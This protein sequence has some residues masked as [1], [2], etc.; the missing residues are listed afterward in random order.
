MG[1]T[2]QIR[3][4]LTSRVGKGKRFANNKRMADELEVDPSQLNRFL[5]RERG[6][7]ADS[8]GKIMDKMGARIAFP[9]E[10]RDQAMAI[11]ITSDNGMAPSAGDYIAVPIT[12]PELAAQ[13]GLIPEEAIEG[14]ILAWRHHEA[15][16]FRTNLAAT[17]VPRGD[18][19][20]SPLLDP[21]DVVIV[22]RSDKD[23]TPPGR[24]MLVLAPDGQASIRRVDAR[25]TATGLQLVYY[26]ENAREFPPTASQLEADYD[27][28][29]NQAIGGSVVTS[30]ADMTRK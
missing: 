24:I 3:Q 19:G 26:S 29:I 11:T 21:G 20:L 22:D 1:F 15:I 7:T 5:K 16:R 30:L 14:W 23:P 28:D 10:P 18:F 6:L 9:D 13:P 17:K 12:S 4:A 8:L 25:N 27:G 2:D